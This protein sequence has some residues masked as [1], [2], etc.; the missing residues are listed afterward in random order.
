MK[1]KYIGHACFL[2][3]AGDGKR[4]L[5]D[6][7]EPGSYDGAV[8]Y[9]SIDEDADIVLV[10]HGHPDHSYTA[11]VPGSPVIVDQ[12]GETTV[13]GIRIHGIPTWHDTSQG[14]ERG[15]NIIFKVQ[16]DDM[17]VCHLGDLGHTLDEE[18][19]RKIGQVDVL[20]LPVGGFFTVGTSEADA[21]IAA[22][23]PRLVIPMHFK[24]AGAD[25]PIAPVDDF[26]EGRGG[27]TRAGSP[28]IE[29]TAG[30]IPAGVLV[31]EPANL[32]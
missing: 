23:D 3:T 6:P 21:L 17:A 24:T 20:L 28:E 16:T 30:S 31:L 22:L 18:T 7:Y 9:R 4:I 26:L 32:P 8:K 27:V 5:T 1:V 13:D 19:A 12:A 10:S 14:A 15:S 2:L 25:F 11:G 29:L